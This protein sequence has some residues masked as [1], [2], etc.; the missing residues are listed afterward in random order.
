[1]SVDRVL[2]AIVIQQRPPGAIDLALCGLPSILALSAESES[3]TSVCGNEPGSTW[4][5]NFFVLSGIYS[6]TTPICARGIAS[7][8]ASASGRAT[9]TANAAKERPPCVFQW[10][11]LGLHKQGFWADPERPCSSQGLKRRGVVAC[12]VRRKAPSFSSARA[13]SSSSAESRRLMFRLS[14]EPPLGSTRM[15]VEAVDTGHRPCLDA[16][17]QACGLHEG[18]YPGKLPA[19]G[20]EREGSTILLPQPNPPCLTYAR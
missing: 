5:G 3:M 20:D 19:N 15:I 13:D 4:N 6:L 12:A 9:P 11:E 16:K 10:A 18:Q 1:M 14:G 7:R 17:H 2:Q 8:S